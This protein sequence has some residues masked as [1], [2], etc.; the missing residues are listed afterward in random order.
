MRNSADAALNPQNPIQ[1]L[2]PT[3]QTFRED[4]RGFHHTF[5]SKQADSDVLALPR[6]SATGCL[7][8]QEEKQ[9]SQRMIICVS[10]TEQ[11][12]I[13]PAHIC[14]GW[15]LAPQHKHKVQTPLLPRALP[16]D[17]DT[18]VHTV[19]LSQTVGAGDKQAHMSHECA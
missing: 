1:T 3:L 11:P 14:Q 13:H 6:K 5:A 8:L 10:Q 15:L 16:R 12:R 2:I 9:I 19:T 17:G 18:S 4:G 7:V